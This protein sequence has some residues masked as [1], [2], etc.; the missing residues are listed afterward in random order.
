VSE[1]L[2]QRFHIEALYYSPKRGRNSASPPSV[3]T[4]SY[5][6]RADLFLNRAYFF[7]RLQLLL[8]VVQIV[9]LLF[10]IQGVANVYTSQ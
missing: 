9:M 4:Q 8:A 7:L 5:V 3:Y 1:V 6:L 2:S 10:F